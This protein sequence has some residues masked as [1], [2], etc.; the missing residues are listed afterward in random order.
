M[1]S[2][3]QA[4]PTY[5][6]SLFTQSKL[7]HP[8]RNQRLSFQCTPTLRDPEAEAS[9]RCILGSVMENPPLLSAASDL[10]V[11][12]FYS[13]S[14]RQVYGLCLELAE[15]GKS[16]DAGVIAALL[17]E[18]GQLES[19]GGHVY[20]SEL[21]DDAACSADHIRHHVRIMI[22]AARLRNYRRVGAALEEA[23]RQKGAD[24]ALLQEKF[25]ELLNK[26][27]G[28]RSQRQTDSGCSPQPEK[29][30][31]YYPARCSGSL[32]RGMGVGALCA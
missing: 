24:H 7:R 12:D 1:A 29:A 27:A 6:L 32:G 14:H 30:R 23:S 25:S 22:N 28:L 20:L 3:S 16:F 2:A 9:E 11:N 4:K 13:S 21:L 26:G 5:T 31:R 15:Q 10:S 19:V 17:E 8:A 18:R